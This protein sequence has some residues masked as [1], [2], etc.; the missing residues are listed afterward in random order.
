[1]SEKIRICPCCGSTHVQVIKNVR[2]KSSGPINYR[3]SSKD[4][5]Y[6]GSVCVEI[7]SEDVEHF[8]SA[9]KQASIQ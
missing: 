7:D 8:Q 2:K 3:C 4:C 5:G 6:Y 9:I 1:M